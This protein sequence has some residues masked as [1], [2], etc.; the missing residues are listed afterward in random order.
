MHKLCIL[1]SDSPFC[2]CTRA[3]RADRA[4]GLQIAAMA[5][6]TVIVDNNTC[7]CAQ[8]ARQART[9]LQLSGRIRLGI[10]IKSGTHSPCSKCA[11]YILQLNGRIHLGIVIESGNNTHIATVG[12]AMASKVAAAFRSAAALKLRLICVYILRSLLPFF[13]CNYETLLD[14]EIYKMRVSSGIGF[15]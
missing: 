9:I 12:L 2:N 1:Y 6:R 3:C 4:A 7:E 13:T 5:N 10:M 15:F 11:L 8:S 14:L